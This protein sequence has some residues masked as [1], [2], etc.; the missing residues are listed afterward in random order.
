M[1]GLDA[2]LLANESRPELSEAT[3]TV[4]AVERSIRTDL[5]R[6]WTLDAI[7][8]RL[9]MSPR[10]LQR[11]LSLESSRF[12]DVLDRVRVDEATRLLAHSELSVT[13][14]GYVC[15]FADTSHFSRRFK[16]RQGTSPSAYRAARAGQ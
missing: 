11:A 16:Q 10:S 5:G 9:D 4:V 15:G 8:R 2:L 3:P 6:S 7:A 13:E 14:I 12:S 1:P